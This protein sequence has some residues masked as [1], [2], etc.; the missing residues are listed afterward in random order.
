MLL[1]RKAVLALGPEM[2][3]LDVVRLVLAVRHLGRGKR[4]IGNPRER[5]LELFRGLLLLRLQRRNVSLE[6]RDLAHQ[7][8]RGHLLAALL[9]GTD[10]FRGL[11]A[12]RLRRLGLLDRR[13]PAFVELDQPR[14]F[15]REPAPL[16]AAVELILVVA[17]P[18]DVV[19]GNGAR[20]ESEGLL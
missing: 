10:L 20:R 8:L 6:L 5:V 16:K 9:C 19:H 2:V 17:N 18:F 12:P 3:V 13:A 14:P 7:R 1:R 4:Q 11:V 15:R